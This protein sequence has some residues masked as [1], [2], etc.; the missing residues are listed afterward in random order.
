MLQIN[1][2]INNLRGIGP[3]Y[4]TKLKDLNIITIRDLLFYFPFRY[5]DFTH[6]KN[7]INLTA[8]EQAT[9][10]ASI[11]KIKSYRTPKKHMLLITATAEDESGSIEVV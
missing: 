10:I 9:V 3:Y 6:I 4:E 11:T 8:N 1:D 7:I 5:Q 2:K